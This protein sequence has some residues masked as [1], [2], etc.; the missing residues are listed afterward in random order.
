M[1]RDGW[2]KVRL[3]CR[4]QNGG[5]DASVFVSGEGRPMADLEDEAVQLTDLL[6]GKIIKALRRHRSDEMLIEF[7]DGTRLFIDRTSGGLEFSVTGS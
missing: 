1:R 5:S 3:H 4:I 7:D 2:D 6:R